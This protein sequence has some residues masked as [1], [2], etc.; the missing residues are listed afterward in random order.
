[1]VRVAQRHAGPGARQMR[2]AGYTHLG[3]FDQMRFINEATERFRR[4]PNGAIGYRF[5]FIS[6]HNML[7]LLIRMIQDP[8]IIDI[9]WMA[10]MLATAMWETGTPATVW[11][12]ANGWKP[13][14]TSEWGQPVEEVGKGWLRKGR[15]LPYYLPVKV[16]KLPDGSAMI[17]EQNGDVFTVNTS[18]SI[19]GS[20]PKSA[21]HGTDYSKYGAHPSQ[22]YTQAAGTEHAYYG[23]GYV[24]IT[25]W[26]N[27]AKNGA[28]I[29]MGLELLFDPDKALRSDVAYRIMSNGMIHGRFTSHRLRQYLFGGYTDYIGARAII[30]GKKDGANDIARIAEIFEASLLESRR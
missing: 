6:I 12:V 3:G 20:T 14:H 13:E 11:S 21:T 4:E 1:M 25:W 18:G 2:P 19:T 10:Y 29:G 28:L 15:V 24:Q 8:E 7:D 23:R 22:I 16:N 30:N 26:D 27:Y 5:T 17:T 9:R